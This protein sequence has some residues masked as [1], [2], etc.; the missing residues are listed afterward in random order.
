MS[1]EILSKIEPSSES[2]VPLDVGATLLDRY[3]VIEVVSSSDVTTVYHVAERQRCPA[4]NVENEGAASECG[5]CG[6]KLPAPQLL[7]LIEQRASQDSR[8]LQSSSFVIGEST[9]TCMSDEQNLTPEAKSPPLRLRCGFRTD[10]GLNRSEHGEPNEDSLVAVTFNAQDS[11]GATL[12]LFM[13]ADGVGGAAAGEV[14]SRLGLQVLTRE[15]VTR[16]LLP[17]WN[18]SSLDDAALRAEIAAGLD[19]ANARLLHYQ[20]DHDLQIGTTLTAAMVIQRRAYIV[21]IG[22]SRTYLYRRG[23]LAAVTRDHSYVATLVANGIITPDQVYMHPRRN[24]ILRSLGDVNLK[25]DIFP[26]EGGALELQPDDQLLLCSDG[27]WEMVRDLEIQKVLEHASDPQSA[28]TE[29]IHL[30]NLAGGADNI[31]VIVI[32]CDGTP[33]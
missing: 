16:I 15:W 17:E 18:E 26:E 19:E 32:R 5:F 20:N 9:Y 22:D 25:A 23:N 21:N 4:C 6:A 8:T 1:N 33:Q 3:T 14:A 31:S 10:P 13:V 28:C 24:V 12:G 7:E 30:A 2:L 11:R 29:L 27:L